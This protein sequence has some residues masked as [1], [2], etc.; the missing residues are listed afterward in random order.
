MFIHLYYHLERPCTADRLFPTPA[1]PTDGAVSYSM[2]QGDIYSPDV[3]LLDRS[4]DGEVRR[5]F[6]SRGLGQLSDGMVGGD[7]FLD[8]RGYGKG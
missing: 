2:R 6:L 8:D 5:T 1:R 7:S 4:F 3:S